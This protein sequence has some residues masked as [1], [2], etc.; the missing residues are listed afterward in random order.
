MNCGFRGDADSETKVLVGVGDH[1]LS[2]R[3]GC[4]F[5]KDVKFWLFPDRVTALYLETDVFTD[6]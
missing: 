1:D 3:A 5:R 4:F 2:Q 6:F